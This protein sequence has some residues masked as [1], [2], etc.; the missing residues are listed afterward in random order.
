[1][2]MSRGTAEYIAYKAHVECL[3]RKPTKADLKLRADE[4][5]A[6]GDKGPVFVY[7]TLYES[8]EGQNFRKKRGW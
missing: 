8:T 6:R 4:I 3:G 2:G 1:V 5:L 7:A